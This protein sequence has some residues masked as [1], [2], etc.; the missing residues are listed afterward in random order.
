L[1]DCPK[2]T[3][4]LLQLEGVELTSSS[5][6][7]V[8]KRDSAALDIIVEGRRNTGSEGNGVHQLSVAPKALLNSESCG[9]ERPSVETEVSSASNNGAKE[10]SFLQKYICIFRRDRM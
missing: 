10:R 2:F 1:I 3:A 6:Q 5:A 7:D 8:C 4:L 9:K